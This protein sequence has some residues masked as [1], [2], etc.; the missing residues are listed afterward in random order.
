MAR[1]MTSPT[2]A[3]CRS[4]GRDAGFT[5]VELL[6][7]IAVILILM[8]LAIPMVMRAYRNATST[9]IAAD[10]LTIS[11]ALDA[12]KADHGD[13]P[14]VTVEGTGFAVLTRALYGP[15]GNG[16][17]SAGALDPLDPPAYDGARTYSAGECVREPAGAVSDPTYVF[18][19]AV[20]ASGVAVTDPTRWAVLPVNDHLDGFGFRTRADGKGYGPYL[21]DGAFRLRGLAILD[22]Y[23]NPILY[24]P[25]RPVAPNI[26]VISTGPEGSYLP[27]RQDPLFSDPATENPG[28][29]YDPSDNVVLFRSPEGP[30][31]ML[32]DANL[33][34]AIDG[35]ETAVPAVP[36]LLWSAGRDN[37]YGPDPAHDGNP[38]S[39]SDSDL[40]A[41]DD[42]TNFRQ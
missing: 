39:L 32:G 35:G 14:R 16:A 5:L 34:G 13:Y 4:S 40:D 28:S 27:N 30:W 8:G 41:C 36:F 25:A 17:D 37:V 38:A 31:R 10:L 18:I 11:T 29:L 12:F 15:L 9:R 19:A 7:V 33:N 22:A 42:I 26:T 3:A 2:S 20:P 23:E 21:K 6:V 24:F 1:Q